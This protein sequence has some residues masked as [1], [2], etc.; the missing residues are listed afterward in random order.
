MNCWPPYKDLVNL[1]MCVLRFLLASTFIAFQRD[2][3]E[4][5]KVTPSN[6]PSDIR[7]GPMF[8]QQGILLATLCPPVW[9]VENDFGTLTC[10]MYETE[11]QREKCALTSSFRQAQTNYVSAC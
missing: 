10:H 11:N 8:I 2:Q 4:K 9:A 6:S 5:L 1:M 3:K 7:T